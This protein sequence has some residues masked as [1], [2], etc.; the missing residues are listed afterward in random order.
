[1]AMNKLRPVHLMFGLPVICGLVVAGCA[2]T[3]G[4]A[5]GDDDQPCDGHDPG[6]DGPPDLVGRL[7]LTEVRFWAH[8]IQ[9]MDADGAM[10]PTA[11]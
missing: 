9:D 6:G 2:L 10:T 7:A 3:G 5:A 8:Q 1:M 11:R 4:G